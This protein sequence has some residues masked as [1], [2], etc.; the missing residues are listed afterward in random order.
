MFHVFAFFVFSAMVFAGEGAERH[1]VHAP[2]TAPVT[3]V[4]CT[5]EA[6]K[7]KSED[8][9]PDKADKWDCKISPAQPDSP[10]HID[11]TRE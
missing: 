3:T 10:K 5:R 7:P 2:S 9:S 4:I 11:K 6:A 1:E 8:N